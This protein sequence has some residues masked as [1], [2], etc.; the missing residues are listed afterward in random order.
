V[1]ALG[2]KKKK[3]K[4]KKEEEEEEEE[5][6]MTRKKKKKKKKKRR[7]CKPYALVSHGPLLTVFMANRQKKVTEKSK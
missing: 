6:K 7:N 3:K 4:K 5:M 1:V 2:K